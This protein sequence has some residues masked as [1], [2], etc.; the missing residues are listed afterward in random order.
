MRDMRTQRLREKQEFALETLVSMGLNPEDLMAQQMTFW[1]C[2]CDYKEC[3]G[4][5]IMV[6]QASYNPQTLKSLGF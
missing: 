5:S 4:Y 2:D 3:P 1:D 6:S